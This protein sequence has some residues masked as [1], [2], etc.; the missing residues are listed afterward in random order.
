MVCNRI[1]CIALY[2]TRLQSQSR[3][4]LLKHLAATPS[5]GKA[6]CA[7]VS[8]SGCGHSLSRGTFPQESRLERNYFNN[9]EKKVYNEK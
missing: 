5:V 3:L 1:P 2:H 7:Y 8:R 4:V 9:R 6:G